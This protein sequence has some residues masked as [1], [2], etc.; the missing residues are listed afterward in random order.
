MIRQNEVNRD[1]LSNC[2]VSMSLKAEASGLPSQKGPPGVPT[3]GDFAIVQLALGK[4][5]FELRASASY[6]FRVLFD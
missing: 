3:S 4:E 6:A 1:R 2:I 5:V